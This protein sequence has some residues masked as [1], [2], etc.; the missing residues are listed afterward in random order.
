MIEAEDRLCDDFWT[1]SELDKMA[2]DSLVLPK[3]YE[4][5][6][7]IVYYDLYKNG[8]ATGLV[9]IK[10]VKSV[11]DGQDAIDRLWGSVGIT[12]VFNKYS[13]E[14]PLNQVKCDAIYMILDKYKY[15]GKIELPGSD[16]VYMYE[17][18]MNKLI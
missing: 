10:A 6:T 5:P 12:A 7:H 13:E 18:W 9:L 2:L 4:G 17:P 11:I 3:Y 14:S 8:A 15:N 16:N 1:A